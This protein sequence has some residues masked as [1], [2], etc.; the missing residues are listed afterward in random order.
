[1]FIVKNIFKRICG[2]W[3]KK[4]H[5]VTDAFFDLA[6]VDEIKNGDEY[7][8]ALDYA[9]KNSKIY[10]IALTG[11]YGS[12]KS[13]I[14]DA[15]LKQKMTKQK[16]RS[17]IL[18]ISMASF[19]GLTD[20]PHNKPDSSASDNNDVNLKI[21]QGIFKQLFY[22]VKS[23]KI[24]QSRYRKLHKIN[25]CSI[26][27]YLGAVILISLLLIYV[28]KKDALVLCVEKIQEA[29]NWIPIPKKTAIISSAVFLIMIDV[30]LSKAISVIISKVKVTGLSVGDAAKISVDQNDMDSSFDKNIDEIMYFFET[31]KYDIIFFEDIDRFNNAEIFTKL[32]EL[33][34]LLNHNDSIK[35][36]IRFVYAVKDDMFEGADRTKFFDFIIPVIPVMNSTN[37]GD[38]L[39]KMLSQI[40]QAGIEH[41]LTQEY[42][43]DISPYISDMRVLKNIVNEF[44]IYKRTLQASQELDLENE[45]MFAM[46]TFKNLYPK[47]FADIQFERGIIK[48]AFNGLSAAKFD[49]AESKKISISEKQ[50]K[51][52]SIK[53]ESLTSVRELKSAMLS[54][55]CNWTGV[56]TN[57][58]GNSGIVASVTI[59]D[60]DFDIQKLI[61]GHYLQVTY[62]SYDSGNSKSL[63]INNDTLK[64][65]C[66]RI[67]EKELFTVDKETQL[68]NEIEM[69]KKDLYSIESLNAVGMLH[70]YSECLDDNKK[71]TFLHKNPFLLFAIR[72]GYIDET[73]ANYINYFQGE[74]LTRE[75]MNFILSIKNHRALEPTHS[76]TR[77]DRIVNQL[78]VFEFKQREILNYSLLKELLSKQTQTYTDKTNAFLSQFSGEDDVYWRFIESFVQETDYQDRFVMHLTNNWNGFWEFIYCNPAISD[79]KKAFY[80]ALILRNATII[81]IKE[82]D[83][84]KSISNY[85]INHEDILVRL[86]SLDKSNHIKVDETKIIEV[87]A[88]LNIKFENLDTNGV[89]STIL[90]YIYKNNYYIINYQMIYCIVNFKNSSKAEFLSTQNYTT[91]LSVGYEPLITNIHD[92]FNDYIHDIVL[93]DT[94]I[95]EDESAVCSILEKCIDDLD[96][97]V[98]VIEHEKISFESF[99][100]CCSNLLEQNESAVRVLWDALL[101]GNK[102]SSTWRNV[103]KYWNAFQF[104]Q[105][106]ETFIEKNANILHADS[107]P[108]ESEE[109]IRSFIKSEISVDAFRILIHKIGHVDMD[110]EF[111]EISEE[112]M[113]V[114]IDSNLISFSSDSLERL[115]KFHPLLQIVFISKH[116]DAFVDDI[117]SIEMSGSLFEGLLQS[118]E[119]SSETANAVVKRF[120]ES[121]MTESCVQIIISKQYLM[122]NQIFHVAWNLDL[123]N[124]EK[125]EL[126]LYSLQLL[127]ADDFEMCFSSLKSH[128]P[129]FVPRTN[130]SAVITKTDQNLKLVHRLKEVEYITSVKEEKANSN[131]INAGR[132]RLFTCE[133]K[134]ILK[135]RIKQKTK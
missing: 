129:N 24:P 95:E 19:T 58:S 38:V 5:R 9:L 123:S 45:K 72:R 111:S 83:S 55:L 103:L 10:N 14:I 56:V 100:D 26:S 93:S 12:G 29:F 8:N 69:L 116:Q 120:G 125:I 22:K 96:T 110:V 41:G 23:N 127:S 114:L 128:Y 132:K 70:K 42:I 87:I 35:R 106:L 65:Y 18:R 2:F 63:K 78:Q 118:N 4:K 43:L 108:V 15:Y 1:M 66:C 75:D 68:H 21:E 64:E 6:P 94:N 49:I 44:V 130:H 82:M 102:V 48:D 33:N 47:D 34:F 97:C 36:R 31:S 62:K 77:I 13:S 32:R 39:L 40:K 74:S 54:A 57:L 112:H 117:N 101:N 11:P 119:I 17:R 37:S 133:P 50:T 113:T 107:S 67:K 25:S 46:I 121:F 85:M 89:P 109:F 134:V 52:E 61:D 105:E 28:F 71:I 90:D 80:L 76:L 131:T 79:D 27:L 30:L 86:S 135:C 104:T 16:I 59:L 7:I 115:T 84:N 81:R 53:Q 20:N 126:M 99:E 122:T 124:E 98:Q 91:I 3:N 92:H 60:D 88:E 51:I 73:Y